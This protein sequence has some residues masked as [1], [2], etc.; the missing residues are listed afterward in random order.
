MNAITRFFTECD[1]SWF[2][3]RGPIPT[4]L[5][6]LFLAL[7]GLAADHPQSTSNFN[8]PTI[9]SKYVGSDT[10]KTCHEDLYNKSFANTPH[11]A[12]LKEGKHG[13]EDCHGPGSAH[14]D[15]GGDKS[16]IIRFPELTPAQASGRCLTCHQSSV[17]N[18]E[19]GR[20]VHLAQ[21]VGCLNCHS[22]HHATD[23][24]ALLTKPQTQLCYSCH[25]QQK[26]EF[27]RPFRHRVDVG[28]IQCSDC[29]NPH[30][31]FN[32]RQLRTADGGMQVCYKCHSDKVGPFT[33]EHIPVK[34]EGCQSCHSP[35]GST[36]PRML[37]VMQVNLLCLQCHSPI[38]GRA[39]PE[40]PSFHNQAGK[41]QACTL[42]H[43]MIHGSNFSEFFFK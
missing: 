30:G 34:Q 12:L 40:L 1:F 31:S 28:L 43:T 23:K 5:I 20:S 8:D 4:L 2:Y 37:R 10:C 21:G 32:D 36:N 35:H 39:T 6:A 33:F 9:G 17:E 42:C 41:Y 14:V 15:G 7:P 18:S 26:A 3:R 19:F 25:A 22:P 13:C 24:V 29:H 27:G 38:A 16:K 11:A